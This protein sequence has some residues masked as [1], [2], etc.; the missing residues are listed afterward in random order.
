MGLEYPR[1]WKIV[2]LT[3]EDF[4]ILTIFKKRGWSIP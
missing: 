2:F 3:K 4:Q 1:E